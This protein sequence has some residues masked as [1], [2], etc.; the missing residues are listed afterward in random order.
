MKTFTYKE[1]LKT[2]ERTLAE[3]QGTTLDILTLA[4]PTSA[5]EIQN[6]AKIISKLSPLVGNLIEFR[7]A[8]FLNGNPWF[9]PLGKW[10]RQDP[11]FPDVLF[12]GSVSPSPGVEIKAWFPFATE[13]TGRFK[14]SEKRFKNNEID[15]AILAW[16]PEFI[17]WG[18][19]KIVDVCIVSGKSVA[20]ARDMHYHKPPHYLVLEPEDTTDRT[21]NLQQSN[22]LGYVIQE[23]DKAKIKAA[24]EI[25]SSWGKNGRQYSL[26]ASYQQKLVDLMT[27]INY[28]EDSNYSKIDRI[29]HQGI[30]TFKTKVLDTVILGKSI[31]KWGKL[32]KDLPVDVAEEILNKTS[33]D[34]NPQSVSHLH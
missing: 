34:V 2:A 23:K 16:L 3:M 7:S 4:R 30:E 31:K 12:K 11:G 10:I 29:E 13:I 32:I 8:D 26:S 6:T 1:V 27:K 33:K 28:R 19:P 22:T 17:F 14:D 25:V 24:E 21:S 20:N 15:L 9:S 18:K 5:A